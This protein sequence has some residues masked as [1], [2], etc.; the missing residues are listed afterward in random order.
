LFPRVGPAARIILIRIEP[1]RF[2]C[3]LRP[4]AKKA[5]D[6]IPGFWRSDN[7]PFF[8]DPATPLLG[9]DGRPVPERSLRDQRHLNA[10][11]CAIWSKVPAANPGIDLVSSLPKRAD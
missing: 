2:H 7:R 5:D 9:P 4:E 11:V 10:K 3:S 8:T 6:P 1:S